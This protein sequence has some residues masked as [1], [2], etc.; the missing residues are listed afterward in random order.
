MT[1][2]P[3]MES[4]LWEFLK[5]KKKKKINKS[6]CNEIIHRIV[7]KKKKKHYINM[8]NYFILSV[9]NINI[10]DYLKV[11]YLITKYITN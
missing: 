6:I 5:K 8:E 3:L 7:K 2:N 4:R 1:L 11:I 10:M 9:N